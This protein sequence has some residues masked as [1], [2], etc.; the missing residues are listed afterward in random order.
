VAVESVSVADF[1]TYMYAGAHGR[2]YK[3]ANTQYVVVTV[4][5]ADDVAPLS[6]ALDGEGAER[7]EKRPLLETDGSHLA[8]AVAKD[9]SVDAGEVRYDGQP[10]ASLDAAAIG[11]LNDPP[12]FTVTNVGI[13]PDEFRAG[14]GSQP[15]ISVR[16]RNDGTGSGT[17]GASL[18][19]DV[20][21]GYI[22][23]SATI[24]PGKTRTLTE[25]VPA[26][27]QSSTIGVSLDWGA[28]SWSDSISV[29]G[30]P[31]PPQR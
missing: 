10:V 5:G 4:T 6:L 3:T 19:S 9:R 8:F 25:S 27:A 11:R 17:F 14:S 18:T 26:Y 31:P 7:A 23:M 12:E 2:V 15:T 16:V 22:T 24:D 13:S 21:S 29:V 28:D 20:I 30:T 1:I